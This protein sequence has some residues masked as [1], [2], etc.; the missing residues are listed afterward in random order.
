VPEP[1]RSASEHLSAATGTATHKNDEMCITQQPNSVK[2]WI[3]LKSGLS[4]ITPSV[5]EPT[6][7]HE[8]NETCVIQLPNS[9]KYLNNC[10]KKKG[11]GD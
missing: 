3:V 1:I 8:N 2:Y 9:V 7:T 10:L 6:A 5:P 11:G 4:M